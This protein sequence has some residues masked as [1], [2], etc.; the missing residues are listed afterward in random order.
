MIECILSRGLQHY[1][2]LPEQ[3]NATSL[4]LTSHMSN[5]Q[6]LTVRLSKGSLIDVLQYGILRVSS[7]G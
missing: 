4:R 5:Y 3:T 7:R 2:Y 1:P 6:E